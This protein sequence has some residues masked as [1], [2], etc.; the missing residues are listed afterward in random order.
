MTLTFLFFT[1]IS[2]DSLQRIAII[3]EENH[4]PITTILTPALG[5]KGFWTFKEPF[6]SF[7]INNYNIDLVNS[8]QTVI[9]VMSMKDLIANNFID[10]FT[11][12][13]LPSGLNEVDYKEDLLDDVPIL[14]FSGMAGNTEVLFRI[15]LN[16]VASIPNDSDV[17]YRNKAIVLDLG[18][19]PDNVDLSIHNNDLKDFALSKYGVLPSVKEVQVG[20][21]SYISKL[22]S[23]TSEIIRI[24]SA[25]MRD[26]HLLQ[27][28]KLK[29]TY[30]EIMFKY[31]RIS[32]CFVTAKEDLDALQNAINNAN[33]VSGLALTISIDNI[34]KGS[35]FISRVTGNFPDGTVFYW[36][37]YKTPGVTQLLTPTSGSFVFQNNT[38]YI[39]HYLQSKDNVIDSPFFI[40]L[41]N[42]AS[43]LGFAVISPVLR[44]LE[45]TLSNDTY[46]VTTNLNSL[47][48]GLSQ[49]EKS[50][51]QGYRSF[52]NIFFSY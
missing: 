36:A 30:D 11:A 6:N 18:N 22:A 31:Q 37:T 19:L 51:D 40:I 2:Y 35:S 52:A 23:K 49:P 10:P 48:L 38:A 47:P 3:S 13:Y 4:M 5:T 20:T 14:S 42:E 39:H 29:I 1:G 33:N 17:T 34:V 24:N 16:Y 21:P 15:P 32:N 12:I 46:T 9:S 28:K 25:T 27:L 43:D 50:E 44:S 26:T 8:K 7:V 45:H 41:K